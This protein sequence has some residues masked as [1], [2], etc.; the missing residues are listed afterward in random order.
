MTRLLHLSG[1]TPLAVRT[2]KLYVQTV[3][4]A[5]QASIEGVHED[6]DPDSDWVQILVF[7]IRMICCHAAASGDPES[8][9]DVK[10]AGT[11][12]GKARSRLAQD[13]PL[14]IASLHLAEGVWNSVMA[15]KG[16]TLNYI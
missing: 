1:D 11:L 12:I 16:M 10:Y 8:I 3:S 9:E 4:K 13:K 15:L 2:L 5:Y 6:L 14:L 7:G